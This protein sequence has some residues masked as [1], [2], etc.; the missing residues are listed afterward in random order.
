MYSLLWPTLLEKQSII[1]LFAQ[2]KTFNN[3]NDYNYFYLLQQQKN[4][5]NKS[6]EIQILIFEIII[7]T[8]S[9]NCKIKYNKK[10]NILCY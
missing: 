4:N 6:K 9:Q 2:I 3:K 1:T 8:I 5:N 10:T 7:K